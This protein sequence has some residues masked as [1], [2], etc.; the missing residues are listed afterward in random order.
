MM[1]H[2]ATLGGLEAGEREVPSEETDV[3]AVGK[4]FDLHD[5]A[6]HEPL[7]GT[8]EDVVAQVQLALEV[9]HRDGIQFEK[10]ADDPGFHGALDEL[11]DHGRE[12]PRRA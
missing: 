7:Q 9:P 2:A 11:N 8:L 1:A 12:E 5:S 10:E 4:G 3:R 6:R